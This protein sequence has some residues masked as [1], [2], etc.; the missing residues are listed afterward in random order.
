MADQKHILVVEDD[1]DVRAIIVDM[2]QERGYRVDSAADGISMRDFL[3][4][5]DAVD[6]IVLDAAMPGES[7]TALALHARQLGLPVVMISGSPEMIH[8]RSRMACSYW[9]SRS[10]CRSLLTLWFKPW[11][12]K[13]LG[14]A[15]RSGRPN[16]APPEKFMGVRWQSFEL[17]EFGFR[18]AER[19]QS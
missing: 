2:L 19:K 7:S 17:V 1:N 15:P 3:Q 4:E 11:V 6:A 9:K 18:S 8:S 10:E 16:A 12:A 5:D 14:N 13:S